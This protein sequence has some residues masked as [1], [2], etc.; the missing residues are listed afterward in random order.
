MRKF[1]RKLIILY[2][3][4]AFL[5]LLLNHSAKMGANEGVEKNL[6][7]IGDSTLD[8]IVWNRGKENCI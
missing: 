6:V 8:N 1:L 5:I 2:P 4:F 7:L 3:L